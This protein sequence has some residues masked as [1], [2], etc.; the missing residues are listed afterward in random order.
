MEEY[1]DAGRKGKG[2]DARKRKDVGMDG[3][4]GG[5]GGGGGGG[6]E[7]GRADQCCC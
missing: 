4:R 5:G 3:V 2:G 7:G 1:L 6:G